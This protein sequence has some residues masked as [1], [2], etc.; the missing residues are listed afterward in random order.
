MV[1]VKPTIETSIPLRPEAIEGGG[2]P[3]EGKEER[4]GKT[5]SSIRVM[6]RNVTVDTHNP[7]I[8]Y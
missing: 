3:G 7:A 2:E 6:I 8:I 5:T 1:S 4:L